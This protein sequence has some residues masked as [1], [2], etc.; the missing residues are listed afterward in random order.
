MNKT[1]YMTIIIFL[2]FAALAPI[3][4]LFSGIFHC[5]SVSLW[6]SNLSMTLTFVCCCLF[7]LN[8]CAAVVMSDFC[9]TVDDYVENGNTNAFGTT[10]NFAIVDG[11]KG[12]LDL[13]S[14]CRKNG[15]FIGELAKISNA[16]RDGVVS[17]VN[18]NMKEADALKREFYYYYTNVSLA[19]TDPVLN[20]FSPQNRNAIL[21]LIN[22]AEE[23]VG[24]SVDFGTLTNCTIIGNGFQE[25][26]SSACLGILASVDFMWMN[27]IV[28]AFLQ[29][30]MSI[31]GIY[32]YKLYRKKKYVNPKPKNELDKGLEVEMYD[33]LEVE[34]AH[35]L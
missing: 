19:K 22:S 18:S 26:R 23:C 28:L 11:A 2:M 12:I 35:V 4:M 15:T 14:T 25:I 16:F 17:A 34:Q 9:T 3:Y 24:L 6:A 10:G 20:T 32:G 30:V 29:F 21:G 1:R 33:G 7:I 31:L 5:K 8:F 27:Y 13:V